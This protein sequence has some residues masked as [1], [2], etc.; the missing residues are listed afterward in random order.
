MCANKQN[1]LACGVLKFM[2]I[3]LS[4]LLPFICTGIERSHRFFDRG[5]SKI[6]SF[7]S[8][9]WLMILFVYTS[10]CSYQY[11]SN[12]PISRYSCSLLFLVGVDASVLL[13]NERKKH[14]FNSLH[15]LFGLSINS[16][17]I[18][19]ICNLF[20]SYFL[21]DMSICVFARSQ[22]VLD[23]PDLQRSNE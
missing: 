2:L 12:I 4:Y 20:F 5:R 9:Q 1:R 18:N 15:F 6:T 19:E 16:R 11:L 21:I 17:L 8:I 13:L 22:R 14:K 10:S 23:L 3:S 7:H